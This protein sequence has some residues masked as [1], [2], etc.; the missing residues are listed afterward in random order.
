M[1]FLV[2][3][4]HA[5]EA[6][7]WDEFVRGSRN[8]TFLLERAF[9]DYHADRF[10]DHSLL[11]LNGN[12]SPVAL[13]PAH[14]VDGGLASHRGLTYGGLI[15]GA[16]SGA[17]DMVR[18][19]DALRTYMVEQG[20]SRLEYKTIP[21]IYH[22]SPAEEDRYALFRMGAS[23]HRR[24]VL[25]VVPRA[26]RLAYQ[27]RR[28]RGARRSAKAQVIISESRDFRAFWN[29]LDST[30]LQRH[31]VGPVHS[32]A[33]IERL[34]DAFPDRIRL[35]VATLSSD[36]VA[37]TVIFET[38]QVAHCQ[39]IAASDTGRAT[40]ALDALFDHLLSV[41]FRAKPFFDF[42]ISNEAEGRILNEGLVSHKEGFGARTV[43]HDHYVLELEPRT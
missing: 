3:R 2:A 21:W 14:E 36:I 19:F 31:G 6:R 10:N 23:M 16:G 25:S 28:A 35:F 7:K 26:G 41:V 12:G 37:G 5:S 30:L 17:S 15:V 40:C 9:M 43:V 22:S 32:P 8:G 38:T 29:I 18:M 20:F 1:A 4:F 34:A 33:E 24:D 39:Y 42:G 13:L 11:L 27:A